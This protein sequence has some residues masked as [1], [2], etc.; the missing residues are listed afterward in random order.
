MNKDAFHKKLKYG[1]NYCE[2]H[3]VRMNAK[4]LAAKLMLGPVHQEQTYFCGECYKQLPL[5]TNVDYLART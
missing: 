2:I 3:D 4:Q 5:R 1:D